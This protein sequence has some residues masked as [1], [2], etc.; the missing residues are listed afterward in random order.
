LFGPASPLTTERPPTPS[1]WASSPSPAAIAPP[2]AEPL[3]ALAAAPR[4]THKMKSKQQQPPAHRPTCLHRWE[5]R[6]R[7]SGGV[8]AEERKKEGRRKRKN[9]KERKKKKREKKI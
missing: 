2:H 9:K 7:T 3:P 5:E 8:V 6:E 1:G 4:H